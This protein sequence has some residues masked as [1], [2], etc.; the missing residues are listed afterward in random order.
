MQV[1][2]IAQGRVSFPKKGNDG[3]RNLVSLFHLTVIDLEL[4]GQ[5]I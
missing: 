1:D 2:V 3:Q 5:D 4:R